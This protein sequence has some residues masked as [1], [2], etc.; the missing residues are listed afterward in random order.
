MTDSY[1]VPP[2]PQEEG[3]PPSPDWDS[4]VGDL[5]HADL[6]R[7]YQ[8][9]FSPSQ[10]TGANNGYEGVKGLQKELLKY[11]NGSASWN[12]T[13]TNVNAY[14]KDYNREIGDDGEPEPGSEGKEVK[15]SSEQVALLHRLLIGNS[16]NAR[17]S[18]FPKYML[19]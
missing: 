10:Q 14:L 6:K 3:A 12:D 2:S 11:T 17:I 5:K 13:V 7:I 18:P 9:L 16:F 15:L 1:K 19:W 4:T 8:N